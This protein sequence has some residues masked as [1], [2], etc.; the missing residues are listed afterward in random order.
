MICLVLLCAFFLFFCII[1]PC[2]NPS[3]ALQS[4]VSVAVISSHSYLFDH[5]HRRCETCGVPLFSFLFLF[6][7]LSVC[8]PIIIQFSCC[9]QWFLPC[10]YFGLVQNSSIHHSAS[11]SSYFCSVW[12]GVPCC[13]SFRFLSS[14][15]DVSLTCVQS[16]FPSF[17][18]LVI[19]LNITVLSS[20]FASLP[21]LL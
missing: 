11:V 17:L 18:V 3:Y 2:S 13:S 10:L 7:L 15:S 20:S 12:F 9:F 1:F 6:S 14:F 4:T 5:Q 19:I 16:W 21:S 8:C